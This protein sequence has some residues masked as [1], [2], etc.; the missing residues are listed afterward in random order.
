MALDEQRHIAFGVKLL[1]DEYA[2]DPELV[3]RAITDVIRTVGPW[4][5]GLAAP[6][7]WDESYFTCFGFTHDELALEG[8]RSLEFRLKA[9][10]LDLDS[11]GRRFPLPMDLPLEERAV[12]GRKML[13]GEPDRPRRPSGP[14]PR[15]DRGSCST[16]SA[17]RR[18]RPR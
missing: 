17:A 7:N 15:G 8:T 18:T 14:R 12:R 11:L 13:A 1:A 6:P 16:R 9:I 5:T 3:T 2:R 4:T 10:G